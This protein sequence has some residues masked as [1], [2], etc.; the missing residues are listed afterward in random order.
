[1]MPKRSL[2]PLAVFLLAGCTD[3]M[4]SLSREFRN[5]NNEYLDAMTMVTDEESA[6]RMNQR[7]LKPMNARCKDIEA[8]LTIWK[9]NRKSNQELVEQSFDSDSLSL[10]FAELDANRERYKLEKVRLRN[11]YQHYQ[12]REIER[13]K[14]AGDPVPVIRDPRGLCPNLHDLVIKDGFKEIET[15]LTNPKLAALV[16]TYPTLKGVNNFAELHQVFLK[17][18]ETH[19]PKKKQ[20]V[21]AK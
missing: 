7:I 13:L 19:K 6:Q 3:T 15:Q 20:V 11:L 21:Q 17:N 2:L 12:D 9:S 4:D 8:R 5:A 1:M 14:A 18:V 16:A 10:Y